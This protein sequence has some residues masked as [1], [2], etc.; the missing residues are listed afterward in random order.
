MTQ[1]SGPIGSSRRLSSQGWSSQPH[2]FHPE[3]AAAPALAR[4]DQQ[5][6]AALIEVAFGERERFLDAQSRS[7]QDRDQSAQALCVRPAH[8]RRD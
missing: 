2:A 7:P 6:V 8:R 4:P 3:L 5:R 1:N